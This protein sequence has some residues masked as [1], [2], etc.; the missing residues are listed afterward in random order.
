MSYW[1][2]KSIWGWLLA[3]LLIAAAGVGAMLLAQPESVEAHSI[4]TNAVSS[5][6][7]GGTMRVRDNSKYNNALNLMASR[8]QGWG[9]LDCRW[10]GC[11]GVNIVFTSTSPTVTARDV[12]R[13]TGW[14]GMYSSHDKSVFLNTK[15]LDREGDSGQKGAVMHEF[16]HALGFGHPPC[17]SYY[18]ENSVMEPGGSCNS[19]YITP[20]PHDDS[21]YYNKYVR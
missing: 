12:Y 9:E 11:P 2:L 4:Y 21:D 6:S 10:S 13:N 5:D 18:K 1:S 19:R 14:D 16:G 7:G 20:R 8:T 15:W 17:S 3:V